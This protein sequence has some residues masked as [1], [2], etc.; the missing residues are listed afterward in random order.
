MSETT[1]ATTLDTFMGTAQTPIPSD[2][3]TEKYEVRMVGLSYTAARDYCVQ[4]YKTHP[5]ERLLWYLR[6]VH[7]DFVVVREVA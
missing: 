6:P 3:L 7:G 2:I 1:A 5:K 4:N